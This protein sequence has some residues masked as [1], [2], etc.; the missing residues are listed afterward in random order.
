MLLTAAL[1]PC[2]SARN[3]LS[4]A[5][6]HQW[7]AVTSATSSQRFSL[8][9]QP[10]AASVR[11]IH[12]GR[13]LRQAQGDQSQDKNAQLLSQMNI[14]L[15][16]ENGFLSWCRNTYI[17]A[18]VGVAMMGEGAS[19]LAQSAGLGAL[20]VGAMNLAWGTGC[21]VTNLVRLRHVSG[22]SR[23][24]LFLH[25]SGSLLHCALWAFVL[26]CF[27]GFLDEARWP[28]DPEDQD[29]HGTGG[30]PGRRK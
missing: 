15:V 20:L 21:H 13:G 18:V 4:T 23:V 10:H 29:R 3:F 7:S 9:P 16:C 6:R 19:A 14:R 24:T 25:V 17:S 11:P 5:L 8:R 26:V 27:I 12:T 30:T 1:L 2:R 28:A 22:M